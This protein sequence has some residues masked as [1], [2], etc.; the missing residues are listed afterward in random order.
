MRTQFSAPWS[1][2]LKLLTAL[3]VATLAAVCWRSNARVILPCGALLIGCA[4]FQVRGYRVEP[5]WLSVQR[6]GWSKRFALA[7]SDGARI[8]AA[9]MADSLRLFAIG[10]CFGFIGLYRNARLGPY[11][12][13]A[14]FPDK[15]VV[16][17]LTDRCL[18]VTPDD[19]QGFAR[20]LLG[21][22]P[23][24]PPTA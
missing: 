12:A 1:R 5:G 3:V 6:L 7:S 19:P 18:V 15:A 2:E 8:D 24:D 9:A 23:S 13:Y 4:L 16:V 21:A 11:W 20:A 10:G 17:S 22:R 14:T